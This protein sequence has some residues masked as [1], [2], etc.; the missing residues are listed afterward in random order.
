MRMNGGGL[1]AC[2]SVVGHRDKVRRGSTGEGAVE[3]CGWVGEV[4]WGLSAAASCS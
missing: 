4:M 1:L 2:V 3:Q